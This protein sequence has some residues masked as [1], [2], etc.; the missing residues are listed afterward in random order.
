[1][2]EFLYKYFIEP[3][4]TFSGYNIVNT[5]TYA[6]I[7]IFAIF[8]V[9]GILNKL[10]IKIDG[11]FGLSL[12]PWILLGSFLRVLED[13]NHISYFLIS[14]LIYITIFSI[15]FLFLLFSLFLERK[16]KIPYNSYFFSFG[17]ILAGISFTQ[18]KIINFVG[19]SQI[20]FLDLLFLILT[21]ILGNITKTTKNLF[22]KLTIFS[23][24]Y[25][26]TSTY[27]S[28][29]FYSFREQHVLPNLIIPLLGGNW[30]FFIFIKFIIILI[31]VYFVNFY[32]KDKNFGNWLKLVVIIL[33]VAQGT[34]DMISL[35]VF[36]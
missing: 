28:V 3:I 22:N 27:V 21:L 5:I 18:I 11:K 19:I 17:F 15:T 36:G 23:Q 24:I 1:M 10:K 26:S 33:G 34:R 32:V 20:I 4:L 16:T 6:T 14:P 12:L 31:F 2:Y 25:D 9:Y 13:Y 30:I 29:Q 7:L 8:L 35:G